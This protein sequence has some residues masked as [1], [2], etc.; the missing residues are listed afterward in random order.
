MTRK[1]ILTSGLILVGEESR[2]Y[3]GF[4][5]VIAGMYGILFAW[6]KPIN[7]VMENK[8]M[9]ASLGVTVFN[10]VIGAVSK[11]PGQ[12]V[13]NWI[14]TDTDALLFQILLFAANSLVIA[15]LVGK[16]YLI[17]VSFI[18]HLISHPSPI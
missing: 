8:M 13:A 14:G 16:L 3:I 10:L 7:D 12:D 4:A 18:M 17:S 15:L 6:I 5:M 9:T 2:S 11:I 1:V